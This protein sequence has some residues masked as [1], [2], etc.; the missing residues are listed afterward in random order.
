MQLHP[1]VMPEIGEGI[2]AEAEGLGM[3]QGQFIE[4]MWRAYKDD[5]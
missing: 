5:A 1:K 4:H 2:V 3:T